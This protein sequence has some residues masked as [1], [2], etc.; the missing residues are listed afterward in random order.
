M[1]STCAMSAPMH[2]N[3]KSLLFLRAGFF[4]LSA[5][6]GTRT[7]TRLPPKVFE[8]SASAIPPLR[9][10]CRASIPHGQRRL[11]MGIRRKDD[12]RRRSGRSADTGLSLYRPKGVRRK[13]GR[14]IC[15]RRGRFVKGH[16]PVT[17]LEPGG[18]A[19]LLNA[20]RA[21]F[22]PRT[23]VFFR[24]ILAQFFYGNGP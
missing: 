17:A 4:V 6:G 23:S 22:V 2:N 20:S 9:P 7:P 24:D 1:S 5:E 18:I 21:P 16:R 10:G 12:G 3:Q 8:T 14:P 19:Y 13:C 11:S 15:A